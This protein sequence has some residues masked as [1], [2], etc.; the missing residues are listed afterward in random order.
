MDLISD[1]LG[2]SNGMAVTNIYIRKSE[3]V[4]DEAARKIIDKVLYDK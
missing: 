4:A 2:H 3:K 1:M